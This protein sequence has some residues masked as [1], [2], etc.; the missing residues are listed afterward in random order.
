MTILR[1]LPGHDRAIVTEPFA[2][3]HHMHVGDV[4][5]I[6]LGTRTVALTVAGIYYDYS[7][8]RGSVMVDRSTLLKY[9]PDQ[10]VTN[11]AVYVQPG[12]DADEGPPRSRIPPARLPAR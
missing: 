7:S 9:L 11:I 10:P 8:D 1:S 2:D 4:L 12:A 5:H 3:K 6:P